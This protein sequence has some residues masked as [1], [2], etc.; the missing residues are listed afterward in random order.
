MKHILCCF[1]GS[2]HA[3]LALATAAEL[4]TK[5]AANLSVVVVNVVYGRSPRAPIALIWTE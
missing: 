1:D 3:D 4:A 2:D 5:Y